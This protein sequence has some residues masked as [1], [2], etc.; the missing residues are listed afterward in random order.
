[1]ISAL[2]KYRAKRDFQ[3][4][5]EPTG[6]KARGTRGDH[7]FVIQKH[8]ARRLHYDLRLELDGVLKSWAVP[9]G[10]SPNPAEKRLAIEVED[11]PLDYADFE[12]VIPQ[13]EYGGGTV[14]VWDHGRWDSDA[15]DPARALKLGK[16]TFELHGDKLQG[17]WSLVRSHSPVDRGRDAKQQWLLIKRD[18]EF[19]THEPGSQ[20]LDAHDRSAIS[21]LNMDQ[22]R[23]KSERVWSRDPKVAQEQAGESIDPATLTGAKKARQPERLAPQL[24]T[25][26]TTPPEGDEWL[27]EIKFDGYRVLSMIRGSQVALITR[28]GQDWTHRFKHIAKVL[29]S[30][31]VSSA[32]LDGEVVVLDAQGRSKFQLLQNQLNNSAQAKPVYFIFD[33]LHCDGYDLTQT[34]LIERKQLLRTLVEK[35][36]S[37]GDQIQFSE[38]IIGQGRKVRDR[39]CE[40]DLEGIV[41]KLLDSPYR[42]RRTRDWIK[43]KCLR[44]QEFIIVGYTRPARSRIGFGALLLALHDDG[45]Q[46]VYCGRV[47]TGFTDQSLRQLHEQLKPLKRDSPPVQG[48][49]TAREREAVAWVEPQLVAQVSFHEWTGDGRLR[50]PVFNGLRSDKP[51]SEITRE[52]PLPRKELPVPAAPTH[53]KNSKRKAAGKAS[54]TRTIP[55]SRRNGN[56]VAGVALSSADR[57]LYPEQGLTKRQLA[58]YYDQVADHMLEHV[59]G[60]PL[61][62]VRCP[63]GR[64]ESCFYQRHFRAD[65]PEWVAAVEPPEKDGKKWLQ[66]HDR[67]GLVSL[68][69]IGVLEIHPWGAR[70]DDLDKPDRMVFDL[71][72]GPDVSWADVVH[73]A[74]EIRDRLAALDLVSFVKTTGGKGL[75][76]VAP[77]TRRTGWDEVKQF[78]RDLAATLAREQPSRYVAN[79][80]KSRRHGRIYVDY[81]RNSRSATSVAPFSPRARPGALVSMPVSWDD[82]TAELRADQFDIITVPDALVRRRRDPWEDFSSVRQSITA[83]RLRDVK[84]R[85]LR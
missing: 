10:P 1:M 35:A 65:L 8:A 52:K 78:A 60:R 79:M 17:G 3:R 30:M 39:A 53:R 13:G 82:L 68:A 7:H 51:P 48:P 5:P 74:H 83:A 9:K 11:H 4:T 24:A 23:H 26:A 20:W 12:G 43:S 37:A 54:G 59:V 28:G 16:L 84:S 15:R 62:L 21:N 64:G 57:V 46:L 80:T 29:Q 71:D 42:S 55:S 47:G 76:V 38:H 58:D 34:P 6:S 81:V 72:P 50:H 67:Q 66:I 45:G 41:S 85:D 2:Q 36:A 63:E 31:P 18:D 44:E 32:I 22:I 61:T 27:H 49:L 25:L 33:L 19:A 73:A 70:A 56:V 77:L 40:M 69:Q 75:H 14:M